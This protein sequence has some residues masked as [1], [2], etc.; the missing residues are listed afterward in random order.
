MTNK[1][2]L[3]S[4]FSQDII[5]EIISRKLAGEPSRSIAKEL[6]GKESQKSTVN[7][8]FNRYVQELESQGDMSASDIGKTVEVK[9]PKVLVFD[10]ETSPV[11]GHVWSLWKQ[12]VGLNQIEKDWYILSY[13]AK[14]LGSDEVIYED[15]R[16]TLE[17]D[18]K[19]C[20]SL[21]KL[22][23]DADWVITHNGNRF[24]IPKI[25]ARMILNGL[26][27]FSPVKS[28]DTCSVAKKVFGFTSNK[29]EYLTDKLCKVYKKKN[30]A[31]F[32]GFKLWSECLKG[33]EEAWSEMEEYNAYDVLSLEELYMV[34]RP[35]ISNHPNYGLY[36]DLDEPVCTKCGSTKL[37]RHHKD[38]TT[39]LSVFE[40]YVCKDCHSFNRKRTNLLDKDKRKNLMS[41]S[42]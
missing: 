10:L 13:S 40:Q 30:H 17:D 6:L 21:S 7:G 41:N 12:N 9:S 34:M 25:R 1:V 3:R 8:L 32:S 4:K 31:K 42:L 29:L 24:D 22:L 23:D 5:S 35:Y 26:P 14:W 28:I 33:N 27:P 37:E 39:S 20:A 15:C 2:K 18:S 19:L 11:L 16:D 38:A 36:T